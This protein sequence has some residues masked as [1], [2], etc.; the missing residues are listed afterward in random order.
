[1]GQIFKIALIC[2]GLAPLVLA[3]GCNEKVS[4]DDAPDTGNGEVVI[5]P[6]E[7][8]SISVSSGEHGSA[9]ATF[10]QG[11]DTETE[12]GTETENTEEP[13]MRAEAGTVIT[14]TATPDEGWQF[15]EWVIESKNIALPHLADTS[16]IM[17]AGDVSVKAK[18]AEIVYYPVRFSSRLPTQ[19]VTAKILVNGEEA[20]RAAAGDEITLSATVQSGY[21]FGFWLLENAANSSATF[22]EI[23][24]DIY[25]TTTK[26]LMPQYSLTVNCSVHKNAYWV[27]V[28]NDGNGY[29]TVGLLPNATAFYWGSN[30][31]IVP[32]P[33]AGYKFKEWT[34]I[35]GIDGINPTANPL[36]IV[37]P[38]NEVTMKATFEAE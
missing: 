26:F 38:Q 21:G 31:Q 5:P 1:M 17:P 3:S 36:N 16:F 4:P 27:R 8:Y 10:D 20:T 34:D 25:A 6:A 18:F 30:V 11:V 22:D 9:E 29:A 33:N 2:V 12:D 14:L 7:K 13:G 24:D 23:V 28:S 35:V 15:V 37:T 32:V 19:Y